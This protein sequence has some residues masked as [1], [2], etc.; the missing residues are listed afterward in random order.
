MHYNAQ[1]LGSVTGSNFFGS[2]Y[3]KDLYLGKCSNQLY[4]HE[5][6]IIMYTK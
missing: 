1:Y 2:S 4:P 6:V 5:S 3:Q